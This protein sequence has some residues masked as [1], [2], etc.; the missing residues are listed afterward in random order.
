MREGYV[1]QD[2][3][4]LICGHLKMHLF[5][6]PAFV[7]IDGFV[8]HWDADA[9]DL[10]EKDDIA[11]VLTARGVD[12]VTWADWQR[13]DEWERQQGESRNKLRHKLASTEELMSVITELRK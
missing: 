6:R 7:L 1:P 9:L 13:L 2:D 11:A 8:N 3:W 5:P 10:L 4:F 12:A